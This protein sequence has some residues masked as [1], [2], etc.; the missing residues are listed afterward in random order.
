MKTALV[1]SA[2]A[3]AMLAAAPMASAQQSNMANFCLL[4][5]DGKKDCA[6]QTMAQ[7][8]ASKKGDAN[9]G[10]CMRNTAPS[11][12][13]SGAAPGGAMAPPR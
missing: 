6:Y 5:S 13:G 3:A 10:S 12:T 2:F 9:Q 8:E 4:K 1:L 7:C 11:T